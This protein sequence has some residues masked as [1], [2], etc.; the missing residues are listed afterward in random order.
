MKIS[1]R[2]GVASISATPKTPK[3]RVKRRKGKILD[4]SAIYV[5]VDKRDVP[6]TK[7]GLAYFNR[8]TDL[9][10]KSLK[11]YE[12]ANS[13]IPAGPNTQTFRA[14]ISGEVERELDT[15]L[16]LG[17]GTS[18]RYSSVVKIGSGIDRAIVNKHI[19]STFSM[20]EDQLDLIIPKDIKIVRV[21]FTLHTVSLERTSGTNYNTFGVI[22]KNRTMYLK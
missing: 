5:D 4:Q 14:L 20:L 1:I 6:L 9:L 15:V 16:H 13:S 17:H 19:A 3:T 2:C 7:G 10:E 22:L 12:V 21:H 18:T 11:P 8:L